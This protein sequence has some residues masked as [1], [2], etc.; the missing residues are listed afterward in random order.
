[1][2][3]AYEQFPDYGDDVDLLDPH[4]IIVDAD[5]RPRISLATR[6]RLQKQGLQFPVPDGRLPVV[7]LDDLQHTVDYPI[8][9]DPDCICAGLEYEQTCAESKPAKKRTRK[10][11]ALVRA[12]Y[13][14]PGD[15]APVN[16]GFQLMR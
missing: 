5:E 3:Q 12:T 2:A 10:S 1:M 11:K 6:A 16:Q 14:V 15:L 8:C 4:T 7:M 13:G 9:G